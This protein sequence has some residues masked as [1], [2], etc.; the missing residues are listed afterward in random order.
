M[1]VL[2]QLAD[3]GSY[4][5]MTV[6]DESPLEPGVYLFPRNAIEANPPE[7]PEGKRAIWDSGSWVYQDVAQ[8]E[9][10][11]R[12]QDITTQPGAELSY[13]ELRR[14][15]YPSIYDFADAIVKEDMEQ[16]ATYK[17]ACLLVKALHPKPTLEK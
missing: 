14:A 6:A 11:S 3:D 10:A 2:V 17:T 12:N 16:L 13:A 5:G 15:E 7:I 8:P 1:K 9:A 4:A